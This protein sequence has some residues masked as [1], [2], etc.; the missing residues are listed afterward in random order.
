MRAPPVAVKQM[1]GSF[2]SIAVVHAAHEA[3]AD[4]RAHRA[5]HEVELEAGARP[6]AAL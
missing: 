5:A 4:H 1:N 2:C 6:P 3:L